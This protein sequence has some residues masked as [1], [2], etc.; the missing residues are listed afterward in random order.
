MLQDA[1]MTAWYFIHSKEMTVRRA[2]RRK[3]N[4]TI[5]DII[6]HLQAGLLLVL[7]V[8]ALRRKLRTS[9]WAGISDHFLT[10]CG[11]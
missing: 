5:L 7:D 10:S 4:P 3:R 9:C 8:G 1:H 2:C 6:V 11:E